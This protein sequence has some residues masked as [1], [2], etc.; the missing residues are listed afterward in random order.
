MNRSCHARR[1]VS[2]AG[3][4]LL[5]ITASAIT[6]ARAAVPSSG[7]IAQC[8]FDPSGY[9]YAKEKLPKGFEDFDHLTLMEKREKSERAGVYT[10]RNEAYEFRALDSWPFKFDTEAV[11]GISYSFDGKFHMACIFEEEARKMAE[12]IFAEGQLLKLENGLEIARTPVQFVYSPKLRT[13]KDDVNALYP[14][15]RTDLIYAVWEGDWAKSR[16]L[17]AKGANVNVRD[18]SCRKTALEYAIDFSNDEEPAGTLRIVKLLIAAG[19]DV[20]LKNEDG[21]TVLMKAVDEDSK[22][23]QFLIASGADVNAKDNNGATALMNAVYAA[24]TEWHFGYGPEDERDK[25]PF[26]NARAMI[27]AGA[28]VN[29]RNNDSETALSIVENEFKKYDQSA[30]SKAEKDE[31]DKLIN[32]LKQAG[33]K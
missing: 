9:F 24:T 17:L 3:C 26:Q 29:E 19:A 13:L 32:L 12:A 6:H 25:S 2:L 20:N 27:R 22:L 1:A 8:P 15:G 21:T 16:A 4:L 31:Y 18:K 11:K 5:I 28:R 33:A 10:T 23:F 14:S 30:L 7:P